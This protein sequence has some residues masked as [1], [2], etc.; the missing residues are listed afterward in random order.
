M[1][2]ELV[3]KCRSYRRFN[4]KRRMSDKMLLSFIQNASLTPSGSNL[5]PLK[6]K[7]V[8]DIDENGKLFK[9]LKWAGYLKDWKGPKE[10]ERPASYII[11]LGDTSI[12]KIFSVDLG[13]S[14]YTLM[15]SAAERGI[16]SCM[17]GSIERDDVRRQFEIPEKFDILLVV[18]FGFP[19]EEVVLEKAKG[20]N[21]RY[22]RDMEQVHHV[23]K[24]DL[25]DLIIT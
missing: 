15:L 5:Q 7:I 20:D 14:A 2:N 19:D 18:A 13:I 21:I 4:E 16:G 1:V 11:I 10:G 9:S 6:Y 17:I 3:K 23:P 25:D 22:Y 24:R 8:N 12:S